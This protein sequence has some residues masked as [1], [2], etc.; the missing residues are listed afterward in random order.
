M[1]YIQYN[2]VFITHYVYLYTHYVY[3]TCI[4]TRNKVSTYNSVKHGKTSVGNSNIQNLSF[5]L[6]K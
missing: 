3:Y 6:A 4:Y 5:A 2:D 1:R